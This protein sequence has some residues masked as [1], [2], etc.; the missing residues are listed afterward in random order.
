[1]YNSNIGEILI[2][3]VDVLQYDY[4]FRVERET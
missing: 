1:M 4:D 2:P 3:F